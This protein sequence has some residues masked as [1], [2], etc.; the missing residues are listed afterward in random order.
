MSARRSLGRHEPPNAKPGFRYADDT[1]S[2][3]SSQKSLITTWL[4]IDS[5]LQ[6]LPISLAKPTFRPW[7]A[8]HAYLT[9]SATLIGTTCVGVSMPRYSARTGAADSGSSAPMM[10]KGGS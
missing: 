9:I 10:L 4:S 7:Y 6:M 2:F 8:L 3:V 5:A 1:L